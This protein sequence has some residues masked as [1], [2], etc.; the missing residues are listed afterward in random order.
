MARILSLI[1]AIL[2]PMVVI[3]TQWQ[4]GKY[5]EFLKT[6]REAEGQITFAENRVF[7]F[8]NNRKEFIIAYEFVV[9]GTT[10]EGEERLEYADMEDQ[11]TLGARV[12][13]LYDPENP[14]NNHL[15]RLLERR[16][17][18]ASIVAK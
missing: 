1:L 4:S 16:L 2:I 7:D 17:D 9:D 13:V 18:V 15:K 5:K 11:F 3:V 10:Y 12:A 14:R 6:A 8:K